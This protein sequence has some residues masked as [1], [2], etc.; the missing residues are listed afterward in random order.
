M[1]WLN[2]KVKELSDCLKDRE[3]DRAESVLKEMQAYVRAKVTSEPHYA[4]LAFYVFLTVF[5]YFLLSMQ[6]IEKLENALK[7]LVDKIKQLDDR[8]SR[9]EK[10]FEFEGEDV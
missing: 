7:Q 3:W 1:E 2:E 8:V 9:L 5:D 10:E 6:R 4:W